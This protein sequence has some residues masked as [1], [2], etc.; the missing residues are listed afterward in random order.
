MLRNRNVY[1]VKRFIYGAIL[2]SA[3]IIL[4]TL[5]VVAA[6][7]L[8]G[9]LADSFA[10]N[11]AFSRFVVRTVCQIQFLV[12][13]YLFFE[14]RENSRRLKEMEKHFSHKQESQEEISGS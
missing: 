1:E 13:L 7:V 5:F 14:L 12:L 10:L 9:F 4:I 2:K 11:S 8:A 3:E 6:L